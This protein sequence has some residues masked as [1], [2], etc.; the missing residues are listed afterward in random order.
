MLLLAFLAIS[1]IVGSRLSSIV[2]SLFKE[3]IFSIFLILLA[4]K[5]IVRACS[6]KALVTD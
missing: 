4:G 3:V 2:N 6:C 5:R 1:F